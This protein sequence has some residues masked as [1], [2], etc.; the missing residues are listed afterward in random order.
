MSAVYALTIVSFFSCYQH[1]NILVGFCF[2]GNNS[3]F[4]LWMNSI[5][6][7]LLFNL[8]NI[9]ICLEI[10]GKF[11]NANISIFSSKNHMNDPINTLN[12]FFFFLSFRL[13]SPSKYNQDKH[14][15]F[16][17]FF[18]FFLRFSIQACMNKVV[19]ICFRERTKKK[20]KK[21]FIHIN[22]WTVWL[23]KFLFHQQKR[24]LYTQVFCF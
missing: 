16:S 15:F 1:N 14:S 8:N 10:R 7:H 13:S 3:R 2:L 5:P 17:L 6:T 23:N 20:Q 9:S 11:A 19:D 22:V 12:V 21:I 4:F 24:V 18:F